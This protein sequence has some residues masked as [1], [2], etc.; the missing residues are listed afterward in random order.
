MGSV[1]KEG[2]IKVRDPETGHNKWV[3]SKKGLLYDYAGGVT[4]KKLE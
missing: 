1:N 4:A 2:Q 3:G